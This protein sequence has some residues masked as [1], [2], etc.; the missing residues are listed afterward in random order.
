M[1]IATK[2]K[3]K[4]LGDRILV[5]HTE[6]QETLR[7]GIVLPDAAKKKGQFATVIAVGT[8][9]TTPEGKPIPILVKEG[10][11][12]LIDKYAGQEVT[13]EDEEFVILRATEIIALIN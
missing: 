6:E 4:P 1:T 8:G 3:L 10:D 5:K 9:A 11:K 13:I 7:G 2:K 12:V